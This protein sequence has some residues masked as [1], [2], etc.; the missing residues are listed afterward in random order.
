MN[1]RARDRYVVSSGEEMVIADYFD[2]PATKSA[3]IV[4]AKFVG[5]ASSASAA[6][7]RYVL[8]KQSLRTR[9]DG[10]T[11]TLVGY[12]DELMEKSTGWASNTFPALLTLMTGAAWTA[13]TAYEGGDVV[14][15]G[16]NVYVVVFPVK[17]APVVGGTTAPTHT[18]GFWTDTGVTYAYIGAENVN[19][20]SAVVGAEASLEIEWAVSVEMFGV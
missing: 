12:T 8:A 11:T 10:G 1:K 18:S 9:R 5:D 16:G 2:M 15:N 17:G 4:E 13:S 20:V 19:R 6:G 7:D 14:V 3:L